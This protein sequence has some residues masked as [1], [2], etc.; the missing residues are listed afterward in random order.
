MP[1]EIQTDSTGF[2]EEFH[3][4][5]C[6]PSACRSHFQIQ[7]I[8]AAFSA[9]LCATFLSGCG[10]IPSDVHETIFAKSAFAQPIG[11][12]PGP[13]DGA[14]AIADAKQHTTDNGLLSR[15]VITSYLNAD[16]TL[17]SFLVKHGY[18]T[19]ECVPVTHRYGTDYYCYIAHIN[20]REQLRRVATRKLT[21][22]TYSNKYKSSIL[23]TSVTVQAV[24][25]QYRIDVFLKDF[26]PPKE[27]FE[28]SAQ[29]VL[30]PNTGRWELMNIN[31][32]D[33]GGR[34]FLDYIHSQYKSYTPAVGSSAETK[35]MSLGARETG[36]QSKSGHNPGFAAAKMMASL[37]PD[38]DVV[39]ADESTGKITLRDKKTGK[40]ATLDFQDIQKGRMS[41]GG[42][43]REKV[44][45]QG[46][47]EGGM[48]P[49]TVK[50]SEGTMQFGQASLAKV[51]NWVP[52][53][54]G[55]QMTGAF[56]AQREGKDSGTFQIKCSGSVE[57]VAVFYEKELTG[58]G[59]KI[60]KR[61]LQ[62]GGGTMVSVVGTDEPKQRTVNAT[63]TSG[64]Q[65]TVAHVVYE[66]R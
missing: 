17:L 33:N 12:D 31:L 16:K 21:K 46:K 62:S 37:N 20:A 7:S 13:E 5:A 48:G 30:N 18:S 8:I 4:G 22:I 39:K 19:V 40:T 57:Q 1:L 27:T 15:V 14:A 36:S 63:V 6:T 47:G 60:Q 23:G 59:M 9:L 49:M 44:D 2:H 65:G 56:S 43:N 64:E 11:I 10:S 24:T 3:P 25:F 42:D 50:S 61:S 52:K 29:A 55:G 51:P 32:S 58:V 35:A 38:V 54:P 26:P 66:A 28:G 34:Y 45:I 53:Y 41:F